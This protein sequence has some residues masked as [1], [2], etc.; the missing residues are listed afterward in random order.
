[1][2]FRLFLMFILCTRCFSFLYTN[3]Y[4][5]QLETGKF[6]MRAFDPIFSNCCTFRTIADFF[7]RSKI[8]NNSADGR[9]NQNF[10][11]INLASIIIGHCYNATSQL[12]AHRILN[13]CLLKFCLLIGAFQLTISNFP[14]LSY[15]L[16]RASGITPALP[17]HSL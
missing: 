10:M 9:L 12:G 14:F 13:V 17:P 1:M 5:W 11:Y 6:F 3:E 4:R 8:H 16:S 15:L 7:L 2:V